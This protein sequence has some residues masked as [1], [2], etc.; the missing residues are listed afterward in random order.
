MSSRK[1]Y[2]CDSPEIK[3]LTRLLAGSSLCNNC[4]GGSFPLRKTFKEKQVDLYVLRLIGNRIYVGVSTNVSE[5]IDRHYRGTGAKWT[6]VYR[7]IGTVQIIR[8]VGPDAEKEF[9][10]KYMRAYG[11]WNVRGGP[12]NRVELKHPPPELWG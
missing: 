5:R 3:E 8:N 4:R 2:W 10:L 11:W 12:W 1:T 9:T 6:S 7:P